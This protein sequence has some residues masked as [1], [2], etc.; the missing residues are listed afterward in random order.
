MNLYKDHKSTDDFRYLYT[1]QLSKIEM[2]SF[3]YVV[4]DDASDVSH[5]NKSCHNGGNH[6]SHRDPLLELGLLGDCSSLRK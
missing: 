4:E 2:I 6:I 1:G 5:A 3:P